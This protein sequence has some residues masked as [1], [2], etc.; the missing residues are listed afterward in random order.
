MSF[1]EI[2]NS[3]YAVVHAEWDIGRGKQPKT[4]FSH[5]FPLKK[6][7]GQ[8]SC[9]PVLASVATSLN[10]CIEVSE[11][12]VVA[13]MCVGYQGIDPRKLAAGMRKMG[14]ECEE[15]EDATTSEL[16][17]LLTTGDTVAILDI[18]APWCKKLAMKEE[19]AGHYVMAYFCDEK[20]I[21]FY[22]SGNDARF[23]KIKLDLLKRI[24]HDRMVRSGRRIVNGWM[25][26]FKVC[27][28]FPGQRVLFES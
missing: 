24:W 1:V 19:M 21:Y 22:D 15:Y 3:E 14:I 13:Q 20:Y 8:S 4:W 18:Q 11:D 26:V 7:N 9:G 23:G 28:E 25:S 16:V 10:L 27:E 6:Q 12:E 2:S 5:R 17:D